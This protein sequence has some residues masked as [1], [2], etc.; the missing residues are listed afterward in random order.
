MN[1]PSELKWKVYPEQEKLIRRQLT[2]GFSFCKEAND[3]QTSLHEFTGVRLRDIV[4][5]ITIPVKDITKDELSALGWVQHPGEDFLRHDGGSF[6]KIQLNKKLVIGFRVESISVFLQALHLDRVIIGKEYGTTRTCKIWENAMTEFWVVERNGYDGLD[7][8]KMHTDEQIRMSRIHFMNFRARKRFFNQKNEAFAYTHALIDRAV[9]DIG[10]DWSCAL[11]LKAEREYWE[12]RN[13]AG[14]V[15]KARQDLY[16][17]GWANQDHHTYDNSRE[18]FHEVIA[19][20]EKLGFECRERFYAGQHAGWGSQ[21]LEQPVV[22]SVVFADI[23]LAHDELEGDFAHRRLNSL[24]QLKRAGLWTELHGESMLEAG[25]NHLEC[26]F[27]NK[28]LRQIFTSLGIQMMDPFSD[29]KHLY[30]EL[31]VGEWWPILPGRIDELEGS[32]L[33]TKEQAEDFRLN[34]AIGSH[35]ENLERNFGFKGFNQPGIDSVL[36]VIDPRENLRDSSQEKK[37]RL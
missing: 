27:D 22:G 7:F 34:G 2:N 17:I 4:D 20:L 12:N 24:P 36:R 37:V 19:I 6:P 29:F 26:M 32:G 28:K 13:Y 31:T 33:I 18:Y 1:V 23:D 8:S 11:F 30:Q 21:I 14:R 10:K 35:F 25:L 16:G 15:Q 9:A 5:Y 3:Y